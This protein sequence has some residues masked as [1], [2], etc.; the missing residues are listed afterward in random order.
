MNFIPLVVTYFNNLYLEIF[1]DL[2]FNKQS[3]EKTYLNLVKI[4]LLRLLM[5]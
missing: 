4:N 3:T 2:V 1:N 5:K